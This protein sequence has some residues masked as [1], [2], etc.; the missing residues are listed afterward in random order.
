MKTPNAKSLFVSKGED[1]W[2]QQDLISVAEIG[3]AAIKG[4]NTYIYNAVKRWT[5]TGLTLWTM[6]LEGDPVNLAQHR[7]RIH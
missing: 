3:L 5:Y 1:R 2:R 4:C 7:G 6:C